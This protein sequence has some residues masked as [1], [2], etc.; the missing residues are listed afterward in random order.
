MPKRR[1]CD[2]H[3]RALGHLS[4]QTQ[5]IHDR[6]E[7]NAS[8]CMLGVYAERSWNR[9]VVTPAN[10]VARTY[11]PRRAL[12]PPEPGSS[13]LRQRAE[14]I[15]MF[16]RYP[17]HASSKGSFLS[18]SPAD[19]PP[20]PPAG[21]YHANFRRSFWFLLDPE[22]GHTRRKLLGPN[23]LDG[24]GNSKSDSQTCHDHLGG[25]QPGAYSCGTGIFMRR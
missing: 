21:A 24:R 16:G 4:G 15:R 5:D 20:P 11:I 10:P 1:R 18:I 6:L 25:C 14:H 3:I 13:H 22:S 2:E 12:P 17:S 9:V 19:N 7:E 8:D 23:A